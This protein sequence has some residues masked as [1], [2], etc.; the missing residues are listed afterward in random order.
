VLDR[1]S[2][3]WRHVVA[4]AERTQS[5]AGAVPARDRDHLVAAAWLHDIGY[6]LVASGLHSLDGA[7]HLRSLGAANRLC[8][9]VAHHTAAIVEAEARGLTG[10]LTA[11]FPPE[12]SSVADA[13]TY[14]D[15][16]VGPQGQPMTVEER[17]AEVL[18]RYPP[19]HV[20]H[21][22]ILR[23][24]ANLTATAARVE[25]RLSSSSCQAS[26][27]LPDQCSSADWL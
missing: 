13:L 10:E 16:T 24:L 15:L 23:A 26:V 4:V 3:R 1:T 5:I 6:G 22:S 18:R 27:R 2:D 8:R 17:L 25:R 20:V 7:R 21:Q 11:E 19:D 12:Y 9:L 14:A